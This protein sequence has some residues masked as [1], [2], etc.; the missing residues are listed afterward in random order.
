VEGLNGER[1]GVLPKGKDVI[2][3][4]FARTPEFLEFSRKGGFIDR[5]PR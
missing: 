3:L 1:F 2:D 4:A 5:N